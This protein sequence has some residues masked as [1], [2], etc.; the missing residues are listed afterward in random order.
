MNHYLIN[1][2]EETVSLMISNNYKDRFKA[3][4]HQLR[5]RRDKLHE[6]IVKYAS[7]N[8]DFVPDCPLEILEEQ[9]NIMNKYLEILEIRAQ[10]EK[11]VI[12]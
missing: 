2:L 3:E 11:V 8:L 9:E 1:Y 10:I 12:E 4:Y 5:I 6:M 7:G